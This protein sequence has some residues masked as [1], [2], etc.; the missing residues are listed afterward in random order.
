M[1]AGSARGAADRRDEGVRAGSPGRTLGRSRFAS[2][3]RLPA[4]GSRPGH[5]PSGPF[6]GF[7]P[8]RRTGPIPIHNPLHVLNRTLTLRAC[9][10]SVLAGSIQMTMA[11]T[12][13]GPVTQAPAGPVEEIA[14]AYLRTASGDPGLALRRAITDALADL[15]EA[16]RRDRERGRLISRGY[17]RRAPPCA[18]G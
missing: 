13:A 8:G 6:F 10:V 11:D 2:G 7:R 17:I 18:E 15:L 14:Q 12:Q 3:S 16:E 4:P 1:A 5:R 9:S